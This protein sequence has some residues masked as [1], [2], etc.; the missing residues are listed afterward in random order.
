MERNGFAN[1]LPTSSASPSLGT[2]P[3]GK[4]CPGRGK[5]AEG[6]KGD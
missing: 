4:T 5:M 1:G 6:Q 2:F 3:R